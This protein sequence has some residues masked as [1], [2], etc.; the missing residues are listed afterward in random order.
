MTEVLIQHAGTIIVSLLVAAGIVLAVRKLIRDKKKGKSLC[1]DN[2]SGCP[3]S[4]TCH[5]DT[6][7]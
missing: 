4:G 7:L 6:T 3:H 2:C 5:K 1:G